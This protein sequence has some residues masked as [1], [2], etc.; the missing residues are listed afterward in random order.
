[1][2][3]GNTASQ[4]ADYLGRYQQSKRQSVSATIE[5]I[6]RPRGLAIAVG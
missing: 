3:E 2:P 5:E 1:M 4:S 6:N